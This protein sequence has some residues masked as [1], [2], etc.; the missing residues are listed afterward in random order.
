M[1]E[2]KVVFTR[3]SY[4]N[5]KKWDSTTLTVESKEKA[6]ELVKMYRKGSSFEKAEFFSEDEVENLK[7]M[8]G[9]VNVE[10][11]EDNCELDCNDAEYDW[12]IEE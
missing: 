5:Y 2:F 12:E 3:E 6:D 10:M 1:S 4:G 8:E 9:V 7:A 11:C